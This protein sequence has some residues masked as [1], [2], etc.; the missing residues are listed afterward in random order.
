MDAVSEC[1][2]ITPE[3]ISSRRRDKQVALARQVA[4]YLLKQQDGYSLAEIGNLLGG[5]N[6]ST[7]SHAC[8]KVAEDIKASPLLRHK[9]KDIQKSLRLR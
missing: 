7:V 3:L 4:M 8:E 6:P 9:V 1:F 5:R 2:Q